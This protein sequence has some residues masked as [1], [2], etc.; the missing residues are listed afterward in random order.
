MDIDKM[1]VLHNAVLLNNL[2]IIETLLQCKKEVNIKGGNNEET[3][4]HMAVCMHYTDVVK[5]LLTHKLDTSIK[6]KEN[7]TALQRARKEN[8]EVVD[9]LS[10]YENE[11]NGSEGPKE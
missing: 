9:I 11:I 3:P 10:Q 5:L 1:T 4:L 7:M 8:R 2:E 6:D